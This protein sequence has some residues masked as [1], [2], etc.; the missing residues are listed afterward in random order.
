MA[1]CTETPIIIL[2]SAASVGIGISTE[3]EQLNF[4]GSL[5]DGMLGRPAIRSIRVT[6][7]L[8]SSLYVA[9]VVESKLS[10]YK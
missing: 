9:D 10:F 1:S 6:C 2:D 5:N 4:R 3:W 7:V 8:S